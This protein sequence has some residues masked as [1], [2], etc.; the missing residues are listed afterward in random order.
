MGD[1]TS[2]SVNAE[3]CG[4]EELVYWFR[5]IIRLCSAGTVDNIIMGVLC[6]Y[7]SKTRTVI[8]PFDFQVSKYSILSEI[9]IDYSVLTCL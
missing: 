7:S 1:G 4:L 9:T 5:F 6:Q 2:T 8:D 3:E